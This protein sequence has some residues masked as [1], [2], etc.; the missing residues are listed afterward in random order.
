MQLRR[1]VFPAPFGPMTEKSSP[2]RTARPTSTSARMPPKLTHRSRACRI[3]ASTSPTFRGI[4]HSS[5]LV[6]SDVTTP[7]LVSIVIVVVLPL[8]VV[9]VAARK[10]CGVIGAASALVERNLRVRAQRA[11]PHDTLRRLV[12]DVLHR[13]DLLGRDAVLDPALE[14]T[15]DVV[16]GRITERLGLWQ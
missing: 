6:R 7:V 13:S 5:T 16:F 12:V 15:K 1:V 9:R 10:I 8:L 4:A 3:C 14:R 2:L 11:G